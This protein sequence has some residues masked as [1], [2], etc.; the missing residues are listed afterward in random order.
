MNETVEQFYAKNAEQGYSDEYNNQ[1]GPRI[2]W[3][4]ERFGL[5]KLTNTNVVDVGC[6][7]GNYF[8]RMPDPVASGNKYYGLDGA[9]LGA[10]AKLKNNFTSIRADFDIPFGHVLDNE[11][12]IDY[13]IASEVIEHVVGIDNMMLSM[14]QLVKQNGKALFTIPHISVTHPVVY[15]GLMYPEQNFQI[16]I[17]QYAWLVED[18]DIYPGNW[19]SCC[20]LCRNAPMIEQKPLF[21]KEER[22]FWGNPPSVW[23][24]L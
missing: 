20:F 13:L 9:K 19:K 17:E 2:Q 12:E 5:D 6:G 15:P 21:P 14:K 23:A 18:F 24:N 8:S 10:G 11:V 3:V 1:H 16:F 7:R 22:K 4:I